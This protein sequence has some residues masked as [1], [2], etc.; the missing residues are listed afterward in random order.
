MSIL[1]GIKNL[2]ELFVGAKKAKQIY[3]GKNLVFEEASAYMLLY[4]NGT[5]NGISWAANKFN[6]LNYTAYATAKL[7]DERMLIQITQTTNTASYYYNAHVSTA[8]PVRVP[9]NAS[10]LNV[11]V[12]GDATNWIVDLKFGLLPGTISN[13]YDD[14]KGGQL[15]ST[16][17]AQGATIKTHSMELSEDVKGRDDLYVI[18]NGQQRC[19]Q[20]RRMYIYNVWFD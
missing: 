12:N 9:K 20:T 14:S 10:R 16:I 8:E 1:T 18:I 17:S 2:K 4:D 13:S 5:V 11:S 15:S 7:Y 19:D 3:L 6:R